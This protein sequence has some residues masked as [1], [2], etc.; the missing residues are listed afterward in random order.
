M[1]RVIERMIDTACGPAHRDPS[2]PGYALT[3]RLASEGLDFSRCV[4]MF[5]PFEDS[6][7]Q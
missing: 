1:A 2:E 3:E 6:A 7:K 4:K 5:L